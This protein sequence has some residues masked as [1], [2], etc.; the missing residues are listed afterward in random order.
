MIERRAPPRPAPLP[1]PAAEPHR[2]ELTVVVPVFDEEPNLMRLHARICSALEPM[3]RRFEVI[4][5]DDGSRDAGLRVLRGL[6]AA[7]RRVRV[8]EL[9]RNFGQ[10]AAV[11]AGFE[12]AEGDVVVTLDAD[13]QNPPEEIPRLVEEIDKGA[14]VA[15]G[16]REDRADPLWRRVASR[17]MNRLTARI[18]GVPQG[19][20]GCMLRAY[21][22]AVVRRMVAAREVGT[23]V[24][25][26][27]AHCARR[28]ADVPVKHEPREAGSSKYDLVRLLRLHQ[29]LVTT[30]SLAPLAFVGG[31]GAACVAAGA[32]GALLLT[33]RWLVLDV[34]AGTCAVGVCV[35]AIATGVQLV[36]AG[37][38]GE[39]VGR[40]HQQVRGRRHHV[41][42][43]HQSGTYEE[44]E[45]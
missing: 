6:A 30:V 11:L 1:A 40:I 9:A 37:V 2:P 31:A 36:A 41:A 45:A 15:S 28:F 38:L 43:I 13:L 44:V 17:A 19:D 24:P 16:L 3:R 32:A 27:A 26:L 25:A 12:R 14:E 33:A 29:D 5:V 23:Y 34:P 20:W 7:D 35:A 8:I 39:Y 18:T 4:Y 10:H 22:R 42:R 21:R